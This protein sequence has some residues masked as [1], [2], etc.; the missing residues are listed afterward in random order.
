[1][2]RSNDI[3]AS[4]SACSEALGKVEPMSRGSLD[5]LITIPA[6][7]ALPLQ[8]VA[9]ALI[10]WSGN[11]HPASKLR[12]DGLSLVMLELFHPE[13][14]R[15]SRSL[16]SIDFEGQVSVAG[17]SGERAAYLVAHIDTPQGRRV[18]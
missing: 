11:F 1:V 16:R 9:P 3:H 10:Q 17:S 5:W 13:P 18:L 2:V 7:G 8:G 14:E 6:D 15:V 12:D 4:A